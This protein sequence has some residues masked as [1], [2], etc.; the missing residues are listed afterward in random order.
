VK[1]RPNR[2]PNQPA[3]GLALLLVIHLVGCGR[4]GDP[5]GAAQAATKTAQELRHE[6]NRDA[7]R[8]ARGASDPAV[9]EPSF[10][11]P[12]ELRI[13]LLPRGCPPEAA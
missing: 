10:G 1:V 9:A 6:K 3:S 5:G 2:R 12:I 7:F 13:D 4:S 8:I 11:H